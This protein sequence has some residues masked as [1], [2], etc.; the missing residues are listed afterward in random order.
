MKYVPPIMAFLALLFLMA[1]PQQAVQGATDKPQSQIPQAPAAVTSTPTPAAVP[2]DDVPGS[3]ATPVV[4]ATPEPQPVPELA[5]L[6]INFEVTGDVAEA[7]TYEVVEVKGHSLVSWEAQSGW[8]D[9]GWFNDLEI[10]FEAVHVIVLFHPADGSET[11]TMAI[12]NPAPGTSYGWVA[13]GMCHALEVGW[14]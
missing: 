6:R 13:R 12:A 2:T 5:C 4:P 9:S 3:T 14:P 8:Q 7:G 10:S 1:L 11:I